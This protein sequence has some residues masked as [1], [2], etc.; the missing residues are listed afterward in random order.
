MIIVS[1]L[2]LVSAGLCAW[3]YWEIENGLYL[4]GAGI[5]M[6]LAVLFYPPKEI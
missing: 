4:L 6:V 1:I 5:C 2:F 3:G